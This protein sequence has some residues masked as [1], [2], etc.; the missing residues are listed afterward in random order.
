[1]KIDA[2][3]C[4][5]ISSLFPLA[6]S[7]EMLLDRLMKKRSW[8]PQ[9]S[10]TIDPTRFYPTREQLITDLYDGRPAYERVTPFTAGELRRVETLYPSQAQLSA[11]KL[12][13]QVL[14]A[15]DGKPPWLV[16]EVGAF[17]GSGAKHVWADLARQKFGDGSDG[18]RLVLC[19]DTF[20]GALTMR[21]GSHRN[22]IGSANGFFNIGTLF[23][24][25]MVSEGLHDTV[26]PLPFHS[27]GVARLIYLL[28]YKVDVV[29]LDSAHE[30]GETLVELFMFW[31]LLRPGGVL[32]GDDE[33]FEA[34]RHDRSVFAECHN[35]TWESFGRGQWMIRKQRRAPL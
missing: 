30:L 26:Y 11:S 8:R 22:V 21:L 28:G 25:R 9:D 7:K 29:Y 5:V 32:V 10:N 34:V 35:V 18:Q 1:M 23:L 2:A 17:I 14:H 13:S 27:L 31:Q 16:I 24:R 6:T 3:A 4:S 19:A 20:Q 15:L 33:Y 12:Q